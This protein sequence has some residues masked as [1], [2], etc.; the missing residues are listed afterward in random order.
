MDD[1][2]DRC[3]IISKERMIPAVA[4]GA[5]GIQCRLND[6]FM[7][8]LLALINDPRTKVA[9]DC[10]RSFLATLDGNCRTPIAAQAIVSADGCH[11]ELMGLIA[12]ADGSDSMMTTKV[13]PVQEAIAIGKIAG[14]EIIKGL[15][16]AKYKE[17]QESFA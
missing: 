5:I 2:I 8:A 15:G 9:V 14:E 12:K 7:L 13:G 16:P 11:I 10:E 4:Q 3:E 1:V 17:F 6:K